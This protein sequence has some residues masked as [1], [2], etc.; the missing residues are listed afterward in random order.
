MKFHLIFASLAILPLSLQAVENSILQSL[1]DDMSESAQI[2]TSTNQNIDY[3]PFILSVYDSNDLAKFGVQTLGEA[4]MLV[5]GV[6]IATNNM[7]NRTGIFRGSNPS[8]YGQST[9]VIDGYVLNDLIFNNY[10]PYFDFPIELI[11]RIEVVRGS[12]SFI[13][14]V[15]GYAG[16]INVITKISAKLTSSGYGAVFAHA[17]SSSA[18]GAGGWSRYSGENYKLSM[19]VFTQ[20]HNQ[21]T[22]VSVED[23]TSFMYPP[24]EKGIARLGMEHKGI[25]I[26]YEYGSFELQGRYND[27]KNEAAFG[28]LFLLPNEGGY[29][30]QPSW[31]LQGKYTFSLS[32]DLKAVL[33]SSVMDNTFVSNS[34]IAQ[35]GLEYDGPYGHVVFPEG[36]W[37]ELMIKT[38][39]ISGC[40][41]LHYTGFESNQLSLGIESIWDSA[42]DMHSKTTNLATGIGIV[43]YTQTPYAFINSESSKRQT[44]NF[45][46]SDKIIVNN[47]TALALTLGAIQS[48]DIG[49]NYYGRAAL[50]YQPTQYDIYK[51]MS[52]NG[53]RL[54]TFQ[55]KYLFPT[56]YAVGN[57][58]LTFENVKS[59]ETQYLH[60][61]SSDLTAGVNLFYLKNTHQIVRDDTATFQNAGDNIIKGVETELRGK[62]T[63]DDTASLSY[64]YIHGNVSNHISGIKADLPHAASHLI[65]AAYSYDFISGWTFGGIWNYVGSK[66]RYVNDTRNELSSYNT[67]DLAM[68]WHM[69]DK[70]G[71]YAQAIVKNISDAIIRYPSPA[72]TYSEDYPIADRSFWFRMGWRF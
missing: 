52:G 41:V 64:S 48:S 51:L 7:N 42:I 29:Y 34:R 63:A 45:Y 56:P 43:D 6:D 25:G 71:W 60:K 24:G 37:A 32:N 72:L 28:T 3:Q 16:T 17:G 20:S 70:K 1:S 38:R 47:T 67:L 68:G 23:Q 44:T 46:L 10:N 59:F 26:H 50:V 35:P 69:N 15:N 27:Y 18:F 5:P 36:E 9:L 14:G 22:P 40:G 13:D 55:E 58:Q 33:K 19:D 30:D 49:S 61:F 57:I 53:F 4:L 31:Y 8:S 21:K 2:A 62:I 39:R 12:G 11:E 65:K 54:P 66:K